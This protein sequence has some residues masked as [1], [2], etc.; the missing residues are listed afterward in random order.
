MH[1]NCPL[2]DGNVRPAYNIQE[3]ETM[4][5]V[6][7]VVPRIYASL[8]NSQENHQSIVVEVADNINEQSISIL[9]DLGSTHFYITPK[10]VRFVLLR[11]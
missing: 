4:G 9:I 2:E 7:R 11:N 10:I 1:K 5:E 8:E 3:A 6:V